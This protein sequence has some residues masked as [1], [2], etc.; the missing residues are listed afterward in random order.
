MKFRKVAASN[1]EAYEPGKMEVWT[2]A[3]AK[4]SKYRIRDSVKGVAEFG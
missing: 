2:E 3:T 4:T 1:L